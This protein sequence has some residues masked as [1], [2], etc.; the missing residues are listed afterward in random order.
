MQ[1]RGVGVAS[2]GVIA[3]GIFAGVEEQA[4]DLAMP[5]LRGQGESCA[6]ANSTA[7]W[8][9]AEERELGKAGTRENGGLTGWV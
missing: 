2:L 5:M 3:V 4:D 8:R 1:R 6:C 9:R 7:A